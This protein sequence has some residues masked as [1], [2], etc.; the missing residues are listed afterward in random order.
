[1][2]VWFGFGH[3]SL[4]LLDGQCVVHCLGNNAGASGPLAVVLLA[5]LTVAGV[6][7][8]GLTLTVAAGLAGAASSVMV[9]AA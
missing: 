1:M 6:L 4:A 5:I 9:V 2:C 8:V 7:L 3:S